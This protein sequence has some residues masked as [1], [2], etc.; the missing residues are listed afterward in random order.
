MQV[1]LLFSSYIKFTLVREDRIPK[2]TDVLV[3]GGGL[4][5]WSVAFWIRYLSKTTVTVVER[6]PSLSRASSLLGLGNVRTQFSEAENIQMALFTAE[7]LRD[8]EEQLKVTGE[9]LYPF[10]LFFDNFR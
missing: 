6:D 2:Q 5:G 1:K 9:E 3:I 7:F 10:D 4:I 8:I